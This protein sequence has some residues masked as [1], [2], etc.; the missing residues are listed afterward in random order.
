MF[1]TEELRRE[2]VERVGFNNNGLEGEGELILP[3]GD[4]VK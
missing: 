4:R 3:S 2:E 1:E